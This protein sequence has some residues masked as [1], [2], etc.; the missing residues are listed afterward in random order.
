MATNSQTNSVEVLES[1]IRECY[2]RVV[3]SHKTHEKCADILTTRNNWLKMIIIILSAIT[4]TGLISIM[5]GLDSVALTVSTITSAL[6]LIIT[7]YSDNFNLGEV[8]T[9]HITAA[10]D[11][12]NIREKYLSLLADIKSGQVKLNSIRSTRDRLQEELR[13]IYRG[14]PRTISKA[15]SEASKGLKEMEELTFSVEE[16]NKL[17]PNALRKPDHGK[18]TVKLLK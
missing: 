11:L 17:L 5:I 8:A 15:Y 2:G 6:T 4:S 1:Q 16:I 13:L 7:S 9:K 18:S 12:W 10:N 3:W 14:S